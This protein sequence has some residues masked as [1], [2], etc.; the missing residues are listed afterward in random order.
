MLNKATWSANFK[1]APPKSQLNRHDMTPMQQQKPQ[2]TKGRPSDQALIPY[3][4]YIGVSK[5]D[6]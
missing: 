4:C 2:S 3:T 5:L 6:R 1:L